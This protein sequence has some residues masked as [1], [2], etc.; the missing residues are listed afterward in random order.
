[1]FGSNTFALVADTAVSTV[2]ALVP[3]TVAVAS[4]AG[5]LVSE[6]LV[7]IATRAFGGCSSTET[8]SVAKRRKVN[9]TALCAV[10]KETFG[11]TFVAVC[12]LCRRKTLEFDTR[13]G[14][15][16]W[17]LSHVIPFSAG[18]TEEISNL[19][20]LCRACNRSMGNKDFRSYIA[21]N[22]PERT[23]ELLRDFNLL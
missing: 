4:A 19:R 17:E 12:K 14:E 16:A 10:W 11:E 20:P 1:M 22:Y 23:E 13:V 18:G 3:A 21:E 15:G 5:A 6:T 9:H 2:S 8:V 7:P